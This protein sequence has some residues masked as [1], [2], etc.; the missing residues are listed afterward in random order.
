M[1][2][3]VLDTNVLVSGFVSESGAPG[4]VLTLWGE[5]AYELVVSA[6]IL[7]EVER[8]LAKPYFQ[9]RYRPDQVRKALEQLQ[10]HAVTTAIT[11]AV[12]GVATHPED[13]L[14][15]ATAVSA[16]ADILVTGDRRLR[17]VGAHQD[18]AILTPREFLALLEQRERA[19]S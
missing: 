13:D 2:R 17:E 9:A 15:L 11:V 4:Q 5:G 14:V 12:Q 18:V 8:T 6:P 7:Q 10:L 16:A 3:V 19:Q 1:I